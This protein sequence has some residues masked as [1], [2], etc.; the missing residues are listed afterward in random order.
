MHLVFWWQTGWGPVD[1]AMCGNLHFQS[2][3]DQAVCSN[4]DVSAR[5]VMVAAHC[6][7]SAFTNLTVPAHSLIVAPRDSVP[8]VAAESLYPP[9][10]S[11]WLIELRGG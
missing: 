4:R 5:F 8:A 1:Q 2:C 3:W 10:I 11:V 9:A 6:L 7:I